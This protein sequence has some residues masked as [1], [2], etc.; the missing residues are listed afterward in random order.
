[1]LG[2]RWTAVRP[3]GRLCAMPLVC[4][5]KQRHGREFCVSDCPGNAPC[6]IFEYVRV[7][8][9]EDVPARR[10]AGGR[11]RRARHEPR[12]AEPGPRLARAR[13]ARLLLRGNRDARAARACG[14]ACSPTTCAAQA[15]CRRRPGSDTCSTSV[16][17]ARVASTPPATTAARRSRREF[18]RTPP[19]KRPLSRCSTSIRAA[20]GSGPGRRLP[21]LRRAVPLVGRRAADAARARE[22]QVHGCA[23]ERCSPGRRASTRG[24]PASTRCSAARAGCASSRTGCSTCCPTS[25]AGRRGRCRSA[26]RRAASAARAAR[27]VTMIEFARDRSGVVPRMFAVNHHPE[28][29]DR[30][31]QVMLL[32]QKRAPRRGERRVVPR[33][34]A[35]S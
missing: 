26:S 16:P 34:A 17:A 19:G 13:G 10:P 4:G 30:V 7:E 31:R 5:Y 27:R 18:T 21:H 28:I 8:R 33:A 24:S 6:G 1:M 35:R 14:C 3:A 2:P 20:P 22:G 23:G 32:E 29:V 25:T 15:C 9:P 11:R 12:L